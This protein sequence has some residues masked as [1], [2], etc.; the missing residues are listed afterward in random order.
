MKKREAIIFDMDGTMFDTEPISCRCWQEAAAP[1]GYTVEQSLF[2]KMLG[3]DHLRIRTLCLEAFGRDFPYE[4]ICE[5]KVRLQLAYY[6]QHTVPVKPGLLKMLQYAQKEGMPCAVASSSPRQLIEYLLQKNELA[7]YF[8]A[9]QS[10]EEVQHGKPAPDVFLLACE[11]LAVTP[12]RAL[13]LEDSETGVLAAHAAGIPV[14]WIPDL[15]MIP[16]KVQA[17]A[18]ASCRSME[19]VPRL[20]V[21]GETA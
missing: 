16:K 15:V 13:V 14:I 4:E 18:Y 6:Q 19:E 7:E 17:L 8:A 10:G 1:Y 9:V 3:R 20:L 12:S 11:K 2:E 21:K 5:K